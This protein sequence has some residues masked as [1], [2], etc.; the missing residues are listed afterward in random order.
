[1]CRL[2]MPSSDTS[3]YLSLRKMELERLSS[4]D[5]SRF[6]EIAGFLLDVRCCWLPRIELTT[7]ALLNLTRIG[8]GR[9]LASWLGGRYLPRRIQ[10]RIADN[11]RSL[12]GLLAVEMTAS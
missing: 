10:S 5:R 3:R 7:L 8:R 4:L 12:L 6:M 1:M 11:D 9:W 2:S